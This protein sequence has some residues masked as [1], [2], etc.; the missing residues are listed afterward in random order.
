MRRMLRQSPPKPY[1]PDEARAEHRACV[2]YHI[3][4]VNSRFTIVGLY[5]AAMGFI[6]GAVFKE[7]ISWDFRAAVSLLACWLTACLWI[8]ELR[9]RA[10]FTNVAHRG[11]D[12]ERRYWKLDGEE[13]MSGF[14]SR[15]H[16]LPAKT[17]ELDSSA[18][19]RRKKPDRPV[20]GWSPDAA[21]SEKWSRFISHSMGLDLL[22][23]GG[24]VFW[25]CSTVISTIYWLACS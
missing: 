13:L 8:L 18:A 17:E 22:Y 21:I 11:I 3:A 16:K 19:P 5:V 9:S 12:I 23:A 20:L 24:L 15:Q 25:A 6:A 4:L 2:D 1:G 7:V 10:L 14:F